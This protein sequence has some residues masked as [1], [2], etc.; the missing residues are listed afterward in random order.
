MMSTQS[1]SLITLLEPFGLSSEESRIYLIL[2]EKGVLS[3]LQISRELKIGRTKVYRLLDKLEERGLVSNKF[4]ELGFKFAANSPTVL[5]IQLLKKEKEHETLKESF[6][7]VLKELEKVMGKG[8]LSSKVLYYSGVKG[9]EQVT[10]N[11]SQAKGNLRI[12]E[13]ADM[14]AFLDYGFC[15]KVR[16]EFVKN[17]VNVNELTNLKKMPA[18]TKVTDFVRDYWKCRYIDSKQLEMRFEIL[19]YN[20]VY[21]MYQYREKDIFCVEIYSD[22]LASM[23][24]QI[25][26][27]LWV[28]AKPMRVLNNEG[29]AVYEGYGISKKDKK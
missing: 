6:P 21:A 27:Y 26:D 4:D 17:K 20:N 29:E 7:L 23:Q 22:Y 28:N 2:L 14:S 13:M 8:K 5:K 19:I 12:F 25:F 24:K 11:S 1:D 10:Y 15:E 9:L 16:R 18:W 3:A